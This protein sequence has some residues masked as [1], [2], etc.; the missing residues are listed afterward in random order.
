[1]DH[2]GFITVAEYSDEI[3]AGIAQGMLANNGIDAVVSPSIM[4]SMYGAGSTWAPVKLSVPRHQAEQA[5]R[6]LKE[7]QDN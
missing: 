7:H 2:Q 1:M 3:S 5:T 6:L 4:A